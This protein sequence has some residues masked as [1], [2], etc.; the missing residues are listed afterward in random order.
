MTTTPRSSATT[1]SPSG[2]FLPGNQGGPGN[3]H[4]A[5]VSRLRAEL[6][7]AVTPEDMREVIRALVGLAKSGD[8]RA[9]KELLDRVLGKPVEA[10]L[11]ARIE[12]LET[13]LERR[14]AG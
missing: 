13:L 8:V 11:V 14:A 7:R 10:D 9:I 2:R 12:E 3:P 6:L 1:R 4:A 5:Q